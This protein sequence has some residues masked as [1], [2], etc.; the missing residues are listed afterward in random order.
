M[1]NEATFLLKKCLFEERFVS[2]IGASF[3]ILSSVKGDCKPYQF[4]DEKLLSQA[5]KLVFEHKSS[6]DYRPLLLNVA[7]LICRE[8]EFIRKE[9]RHFLLPSPEKSPLISLELWKEA[10]SHPEVQMSI[11]S[12]EFLFLLCGSQVSRLI[13]HLGF[14]SCAGYL[15]MKGLLHDQAVSSSNN[16]ELSSD[17]E[18]FSTHPSTP[19]NSNGP[20]PETEEEIQEYESLMA[21]ICEFNSRATK[22]K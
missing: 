18:Y 4:V 6:P 7:L 10:L 9:M 22:Q 14:G 11:S 16:H 2:L 15:H 1:C 20:V 12:G 8:N 5:L 21:K 19:E 17:E 3:H 13:S